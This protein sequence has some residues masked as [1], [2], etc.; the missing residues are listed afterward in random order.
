[1]VGCV[2]SRRRFRGLTVAAVLLL[3][4]V[5]TEARTAGVL[6]AA[7]PPAT[8]TKQDQSFDILEF[9]VL[10][11]SVLDARAVERAVYP[12]LG[13]RR[14]F[15]D[16]EAARSALESAYHERGF[17]TVFVD[18]PEQSVEEGVI[19][20]RVSEGRVHALTVSGAKYFSERQIKAAV[21]EAAVGQVPNLPELQKEVVA[22]NAAAPD[23]AVVPVLKAG[24]ELGTVDVA[25]KVADHL[26]L[27]A[28]LELSNQYTAGTV[29]LRLTGLVSYDNLFGAM[30]SLS[31]QYQTAPQKPSEAAV[32]A[33]G[34]VAP[35]GP[36]KV[37][38][39][40]IHSSSDVA[41]VSAL[42]VIGKGWIAG[43]KYD[44]PF[45]VTR[46]GVQ[47]V[48]LGIDYKR[49][50]QN[51]DVTP[52]Q[53]VATPVSYANFYA[54]Y[55]GSRFAETRALTWSASASFS[56]PGIGSTA[57]EFQNKCYGCRANYFIVRADGSITQQLGRGFE[58]VGRA[59]GQYAVEPLPNNEQFY[60][61]GAQTVRGYYEVEELGDFGARGTIEVRMPSVF[62][63]SER[64]RLQPFV[65]FDVGR[66]GYEL[67]LESQPSNV[68]LSSSGAGFDL[69]AFKNVTGNLTWATVHHTGLSTHSGDSRWLFDVR[70]AW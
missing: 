14:V 23:R 29:P 13:P 12:Y 51:V 36:G 59:A 55:S 7:A 24:P 34:F 35:R 26:P 65:F 39:S 49:F 40:F 6:V 56:V 38:F 19:R 70:A 21:P 9:R 4:V 44:L 46:Q 17:G 62:G 30:D 60:I 50:D 28:S 18:V 53:T 48:A 61:G 45:V 20:L 37:S 52:T 2:R 8:A 25:L 22:V 43:V 1:M 68:T 10:G 47:S 64:V 11:N 58:I 41:V 66:I 15:A 57:L 5:R 63:R 69:Q 32:F 27:H 67:P 33:A 42:A 31:L 54:L 16:V 3:A